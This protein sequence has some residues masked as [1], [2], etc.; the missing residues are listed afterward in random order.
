MLALSNQPRTHTILVTIAKGG[1]P[2]LQL[3]AIR[4][5][6]INRRRE[7]ADTRPAD[8]ARAGRD[9]QLRAERRREARHHPGV[10]RQ[11]RSRALV[12]VAART[13]AGVLDL[14][15]EAI[16]QLASRE[17]SAGAVV[18]LPEGRPTRS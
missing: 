9:L 8:S 17:G 4:Y 18:D 3:K 1:N 7:P 12:D 6:G 16:N 2:D 15:R 13:D 5:L 14:R 10:R 11:R